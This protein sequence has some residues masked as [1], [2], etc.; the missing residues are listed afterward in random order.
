MA[1]E[2]DTDALTAMQ[3]LTW[4]LELIEQT[5]DREAALHAGLA[6]EAL[7]KRVPRSAGAPAPEQM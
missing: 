5:G 4:A 1:I 6:L 2:F 7:R 3:Y